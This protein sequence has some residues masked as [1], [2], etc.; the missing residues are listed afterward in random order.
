MSKKRK[1]VLRDA[2]GE[3]RLE[4]FFVN[5]KQKKRKIRLIDGLPVDEF[6]ARNADDIFLLQ[7]GMYEILHQREMRRRAKPGGAPNIG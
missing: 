5:G 4:I 7:E 3:Y 1:K 2:Q 6:V